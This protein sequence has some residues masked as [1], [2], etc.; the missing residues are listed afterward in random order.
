MGGLL[1]GLTSVGSGSIIIVCLMLIYPQLRG[2]QLVGT[3]LVQAVPLVTAAAIAH[4]IVGDF[5]LGLTA[6]ILIGAIPAVY[7]GAR[8]SSKAPD[9][10]IRPALVFV[11][12]ASALK[13]LE[14]PTVALGVVLLVVALVGLPLWASVDAASF[15]VATWEAIDLQR[16]QW[17]KRL[18]LT[19]PIGV[20]FV[21]GLQ[22]FL[23]VR[24]RLV[25]VPTRV[26]GVLPV[27][28]STAPVVDG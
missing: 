8:L 12:L 4:I 28:L 10:V 23:K 13:L 1:V 5:V 19:A 2:A 6:A 3:D 11:L 15:P 25:T 27:G 22:Y 18:F 17:I 21:L 26:G 20:G 7:V 16:D 9:G 14:V 24:P